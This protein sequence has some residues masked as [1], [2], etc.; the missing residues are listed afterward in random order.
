[1]WN[2]PCS[3]AVPPFAILEYPFFW[4][5][6]D[7]S[8][9]FVRL[10]P[11]VELNP[12]F[13]CIR[14]FRYNY[15]SSKQTP[16]LSHLSQWEERLSFVCPIRGLVPPA[17]DTCVLGF[18]CAAIQHRD[19]RWGAQAGLGSCSPFFLM[20]PGKGKLY[21]GSLILDEI[22]CPTPP[23]PFHCEC[24]QLLGFCLLRDIKSVA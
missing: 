20:F 9:P 14:S 22:L 17:G 24:H 10:F 15:V 5:F 19:G 18:M 3:Q 11:C 8:C 12:H 2:S 21:W 16:I 4:S 1:M 6:S 13:L 7:K 23:S